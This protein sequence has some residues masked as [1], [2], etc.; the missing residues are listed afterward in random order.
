HEVIW[1]EDTIQIFKDE[2]IDKV[3]EIH[4][5]NQEEGTEQW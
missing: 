5:V 4:F 3:V 1:S 2:V